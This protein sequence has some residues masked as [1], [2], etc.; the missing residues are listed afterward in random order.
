MNTTWAAKRVLVL[1]AGRTGLAVARFLSARQARVVLADRNL[2]KLSDLSLPSAVAVCSEHNATQLVSGFDLVVTSPG[3]PP[4]NPVLRRAQELRLPIWSEIEL[5]ARH[6]SVPIVA[7][8]G[9]NGKS[10][11]TVLLGE[12]CRQ[13]GRRAFVG[14]NLGTPLI[15]AVADQGCTLV[16]AEVSSFQLEWV[17]CLQPHVG[18]F[19]NLSPDHLDRYPDLDAYGEAKLRLFARQGPTD[20]A[21]LNRDD[22]WIWSQRQRIRSTLRTFAHGHSFPCH[23]WVERERLC[24]VDE[25]AEP[26]NLDLSASA[27]VGVH[28]RENIMAAALAARCLQL[29]AAA[30]QAAL[31]SMRPLPH[32][33]ELVREWRGVRFYD[34]SKGTNVGA[35]RM[36]L[37][38]FDRPVV[39]L[40]GGYEKG[41]NYVCLASDFQQRVRHAVFFGASGP[42]WAAQLGRFVAHTVVGSLKQGVQVAAELAKPGDIVLLSPGCASFDEFEDFAHRG[43]CF[44][45]WVQEL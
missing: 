9:T 42:K 44:R 15:E 4:T 22:A 3:V 18:V 45:Q 24:V 11:T 2:A 30:V 31:N 36:S 39:L 6:L 38:S 12:I 41:G 40:A 21:I 33:L 23:A 35:V 37:A 43:Q 14:G 29:P 20:F 7:I 5:A 10:T 28:N 32:R 17:E 34:D 8:T 26:W 16:V 13:A 19:L 1:G 25:G 27:L